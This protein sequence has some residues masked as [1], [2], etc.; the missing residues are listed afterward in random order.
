MNNL[1]YKK[2]RLGIELQQKHLKKAN[3]HYYC[4][5]LKYTLG[6]T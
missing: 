3:I 4:Q 1:N 2:Q 5:T 6:S